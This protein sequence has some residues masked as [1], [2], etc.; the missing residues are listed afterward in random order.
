MCS[1]EKLREFVV[2][3]LT[4]AADD[5]FGVFQRTIV[6]YQAE[7]DRQRRLLDIVWK[8]HISLHR[9]DVPKQHECKEGEV[10]VDQQLC[11]QE[12]N[13]SLDQEEPEPPKIKEEQDELCSSQEGAEIIVKQETDTFMWTPI[14]EDSDHSEP[15]QQ[16]EQHHLSHNSHVN[17]N[18]DSQGGKPQNSI[19]SGKLGP[20]QKKRL[21]KRNILTTKTS[22]IDYNPQQSQKS[23]KCD[24]C[25][26]EVKN[27]SELQT[28][29]RFHDG[30]ETH[31]CNICGQMF[32]YKTELTTHTRSHTGERPFSC[33]SCGKTFFRISHLK[34]H[35]IV[36]THE[37]PV[38]CETCGKTFRNKWELKIHMRTHTGERPFTCSTCGKGFVRVTYLN[39]H[40]RTHT[41]ERP[42]SCDTCGKS[43]TKKCNLDQHIRIHT[44]EK[45]YSCKECDRSFIDHGVLRAHMRRAHTGERPYLCKTCGKKFYDSS[46]LSQHKK[47]HADK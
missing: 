40:M 16:N 12:R 4:A 2:E 29:Q 10:V 35:Y 34:A 31:S 27:K 20:T 7:I 13:F 41:G 25:G 45:P 44:G 5:I 24:T 1:T 19:S 33:S 15:E 42:Y 37:R 47:V 23:F 46:N 22:K 38:T 43:F 32:S 18:Q 8:P 9:I 14:P 36:H 30:K 39:I 17:E 28:H 3:R 26:E 6:E 21:G 11:N